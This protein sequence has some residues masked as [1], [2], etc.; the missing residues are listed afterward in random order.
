MGRITIM[1]LFVLFFITAVSPALAST[2]FSQCLLDLQSGRLGKDGGRDNNGNIVEISRATAIS[3]DLCVSACGSGQEPFNWSAFSQ[4]FSSW[5]LPWLALTSQLPFGAHD[6]L[7]NFISVI[8]AVGSPTLAAYSVIMTVLNSRWVARRFRGI[9]YPNAQS[10]MRILSSLQQASVLVNRDL[11][12]S[13]IVLPE[14]DQ[15]WIDLKDHLDYTHTWSV[16]A[17]TSIAWVVIAYIFTVIDS[18]TA[19]IEQLME[20][21]GQGVGSVW[22]WLL[23]VVIAWLQISPKCDYQ[24]VHKAVDNANARTHAPSAEIPGKSVLARAGDRAIYLQKDDLPLH[25]DQTCTAP[26]F[27]YSRVFSWTTAVE[28]VYSCFHQADMNATQSKPVDVSKEWHERDC[29][30]RIHD[31]NRRGTSEQV[32]KYCHFNPKSGAIHQQSSGVWSRILVASLMALFLQWGTTGAALIIVLFTPTRGLGCRSSSYLAYA[33]LSTIVWFLLVL[34]SVFAHYSTFGTSDLERVSSGTFRRS[35][36][37][38]L[39]ITLR[40][41]GKIIATVN[42]IGIVVTNM[43]QLGAVFDRCYCDSS[44]MG[45]GQRAYNVIALEE[46]DVSSLKNAWLGGLFL[47]VGTATIFVGILNLLINPQQS[48]A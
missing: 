43:F 20:V 10:A 8:L 13:L 29:N 47:A 3:Y 35:I 30:V 46:N 16:S 42:A 38:Y 45:L 15:W 17:A 26:I 25:A 4:E 11:L 39:S 9:S 19:D 28:E 21:N 34:S 32:R 2:N 48:E 6:K 12:P 31:A 41:L 24:R 36:A 1:M 33:S 44:V 22:L 5:L 40:R 14:N 27:N 7:D 23:P 37:S 18:F